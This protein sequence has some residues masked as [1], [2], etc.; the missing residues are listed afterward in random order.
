MTKENDKQEAKSAGTIIE[1]AKE[2]WRKISVPLASIVLALFIGG[3][4]IAISGSDPFEA[5]GALFDSAFG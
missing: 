3:L 2:L 1:G 4:L 5:Y